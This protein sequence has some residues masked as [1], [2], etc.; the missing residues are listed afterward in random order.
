MSLWA[1]LTK[2]CISKEEAEEKYYFTTSTGQIVSPEGSGY[3]IPALVPEVVE[4]Q[5]YIPLDFAQQKVKDVTD[6]ANRLR[7]A[8]QKHLAELDSF[9]RQAST[10]SKAHYEGL[11]KDLKAKASRHVEIRKQMQAASEEKLR[12]ELKAS[13]DSVEELRDSMASLNREYQEEVRSLKTTIGE[14]IK[15]TDELTKEVTTLRDNADKVE[16]AVDLKHNTINET[17]AACRDTLL[18]ICQTIEIQRMKEDIYHLEN[19]NAEVAALQ[20][21]V[22]AVNEKNRQ[23][24][25]QLKQ[26]EQDRI[27]AAELQEQS[28]QY[29]IAVR[30]EHTEQL[31][32]LALAHRVKM[33][34]A[35]REYI[36]QLGRLYNRL[37]RSDVQN[38]VSEMCTTIAQQDATNALSELN[39]TQQQNSLQYAHQERALIQKFEQQLQTQRDE[40]K[41]ESDSLKK[42]FNHK[43][44]QASTRIR[45]AE[46]NVVLRDLVTQVVERNTIAGSAVAGAAML[47]PMGQGGKCFLLFYTDVQISCFYACVCKFC[48]IKERNWLFLPQ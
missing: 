18:S 7:E 2:P 1:R 9:Y 41:T 32:A 19:T 26:A 4:K 13:E 17:R 34:E 11:I 16:A 14:G 30:N 20:A 3:V 47:G 12:G 33:L 46:V 5:D 43:M 31:H 39:S 23:C 29:L 36:T 37:H 6:E 45:T 22:L 40:F 48:L 8:Y 25:L 24:H 38:V 35:R 28:A 42:K 21:E 10:D 44:G 27:E 15:K